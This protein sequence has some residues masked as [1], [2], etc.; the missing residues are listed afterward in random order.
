ML[1]CRAVQGV[2]PVGPV[3]PIGPVGCGNEQS[4]LAAAVSIVVGGGGLVAPLPFSVAF[5]VLTYG[6]LP[7]GRQVAAIPDMIVPGPLSDPW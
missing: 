1:L 2:L 3:E 7:E 6:T 5:Q 4:A